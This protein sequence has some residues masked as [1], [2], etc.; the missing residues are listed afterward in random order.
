MSGS[1]SSD[2]SD[3]ECSIKNNNPLLYESNRTINNMIHYTKFQLKTE[4]KRLDNMLKATEQQKK[5]VETLQETYKLLK[6]K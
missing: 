3:D 2:S 6:D 5:I 4:M 1:D